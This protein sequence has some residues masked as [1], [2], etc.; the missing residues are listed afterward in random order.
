VIAR[1][2]LLL[3]VALIA[4]A[5]IITTEFPFGELMRGRA[6]TA[7]ESA[8]LSRLQAQNRVLADQVVSLYE[9]ATVA[10]IAHAEYGLVSKGERSVIVLPSPSAEPGAGSGPLNATTVPPS[11]LVPTDAIVSPGGGAG[12]KPVKQGG[13]WSRLLERLEFWKAVP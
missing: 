2:R 5:V 8:Q 1:A 9:D 3:L 10:R 11:D 12:G 6:T 7:E 13:F 4:G